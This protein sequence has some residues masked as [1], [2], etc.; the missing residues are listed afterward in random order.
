VRGAPL[1]ICSIKPMTG[2]YRD[3]FCNGARKDMGV[4]L[5]HCSLFDLKHF[6]MDLT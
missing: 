1:D 5:A 3:G 4:A 6:A 2:F